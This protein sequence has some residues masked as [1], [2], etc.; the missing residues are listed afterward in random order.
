MC[1]SVCVHVCLISCH[2]GELYGNPDGIYNNN[3]F[4]VLATQLVYTVLVSILY[5]GSFLHGL[6]IQYMYSHSIEC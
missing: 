1:V 6:P 2:V 5:S 3:T 4:L